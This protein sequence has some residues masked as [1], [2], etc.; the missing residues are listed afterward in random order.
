MI[1]VLEKRPRWMP[2]LQRQLLNDRIVL[3]A[4]RSVVD[5][6]DSYLGK[7]V[8]IDLEVGMQECLRLLST[9]NAR[10]II[11]IGTNKTDVLE[12][13]LRELGVTTY[14]QQ[15]IDARQLGAQCRAALEFS[16]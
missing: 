14:H 3:Q 15:P 13:S 4:F 9:S 7:I 1:A 10:T 8:V 5:I 2:E 16:L 12:P 11:A 6:N